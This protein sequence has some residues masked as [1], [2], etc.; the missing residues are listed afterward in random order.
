MSV[1][2]KMQNINAASLAHI[3][4]LDD[5]VRLTQERI[6]GQH[7]AFVRESLGELLESLRHERQGY[8]ALLGMV[9][10]GMAA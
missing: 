1:M 10:V 3:E 7:D 5:F 4:L 8:V 6:S 2:T 9:G